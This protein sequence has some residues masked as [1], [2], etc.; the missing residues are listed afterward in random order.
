M[1]KLMTPAEL[2]PAISVVCPAYNSS[3]FVLRTLESVVGQTYR[4]FEIIISDDGSTDETVAIVKEFLRDRPDIRS[5]VLEGAH[6]GPGAARN[7]GIKRSTTDW[8]AFI[9]SDDIW[10]PNK[11]ERVAEGI[12]EHP[13]A[14]LVCHSERHIHADGSSEV[15]DYGGRYNSHKPLGPQ[16]Y[17]MTL[18]STSAVTCRRSL[19]YQAGLFDESMMS[20]QDFELWVRMAPYATPFFLRG[21]LGHYFDRDGSVS[22][23]RHYERWKNFLRVAI[24][25]RDKVTLAGLLYRLSR[26]TLS[27]CVRGVSRMGWS[28]PWKCDS[29]R[30]SVPSLGGKGDLYRSVHVS[31]ACPTVTWELVEQPSDLEEWDRAL[32]QCAAGSVF[33]SYKWGEY[34]R[35]AGWVPMRWIAWNADKAVVAM[36]Q[37]LTK[38]YPAGV[39][40]GWAPGGPV[41]RFSAT[42]AQDLARVVRGLL[43][44]MNGLRKRVSLRFDSH[45]PLDSATAHAFGQACKRPIACLNSGYS[46]RVDLTKP[47][48][49]ILQ[50][51]TAKHRYY[52]KKALGK[53][54][55][56]KTGNDPSLVRAL[57]DLH[58]EMV[59]HKGLA[60]QGNSFADL[61]YFCATLGDHATILAGYVDD[62]PVTSCLT[63][64]FGQKAFYLM[65]A[66]GRRG[67]E[68]SAAYAMV[69]HLLEHLQKRALTELDLGGVTPRSHLAGGVDHFKRGFGGELLEYL[70]EWEWANAE[71]L[72]WGMN[73]AVRFRRVRL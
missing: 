24:R 55:Q 62:E 46:I 32:E 28:R 10:L 11:L 59:Q 25:H 38:S 27:F 52:V 26:V 70:G 2:R 56:W 61:S 35:A 17:N 13:E 71:W 29:A 64:T 40:V 9:D 8:I 43:D 30:G 5:V 66:T 67:R 51:M 37:I 58:A 45:L 21:I 34:K 57:C 31:E 4:P 42:P 73:L 16:L 1:G 33:Q 50:R 6:R 12:I 54:I 36:C 47:M 14:N 7:A 49:V 3:S 20:V 60:S 65:A 48:D 15:Y 72:R 39:M 19:L 22:S 53:P 23:H 44:E 18:F 68:V 41:P 69:Y 63:L